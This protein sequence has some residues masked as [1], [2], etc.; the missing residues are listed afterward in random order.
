MANIP[1]IK[2]RLKGIKDTRQITKA[3]ELISISKMRKALARF[4][5]NL[6]YFKKIRHT[7]KDIITHSG[8]DAT[9]PYLTR[10][11]GKR[12]AYIVIAADKGLAGGYNKN[13]CETA[14]KHMQTRSKSF[15]ITVGHMAREFFEKKGYTV[16]IDF[17]HAIQ[18][19]RLHDARVLA[20]HI[21]ESYDAELMDEVLLVFTRL[22]STMSQK[23]VIIKLLPVELEDL[24]D[25]E[26]ETHYTQ[27]ILYDMSPRKV[28]DML[29]PQY[30]VGLIYTALVQ[31]AASEH[32][33]RMISM[34]GA[35]K[36][37]DAM[38]EE[39]MLE[40]NRARQSQITGS[41]IEIIT[42]ANTGFSASA[43]H[44]GGD[45]EEDYIIRYPSE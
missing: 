44:G 3:M 15:I 4:E 28:L 13:V 39:L 24:A 33:M 43:F 8:E 11:E 27:E 40:Y 1:D 12:T 37:A 21:L 19:P 17:L 32:C 5:N 45:R 31:A 14:L 2:R 42:A 34:T 30:I 23:P 36:N 9:H 20:A 38:T 7:I 22:K 6:T 29:V 41:M 10:R 35:T 16:D 26:L 18:N 25:I